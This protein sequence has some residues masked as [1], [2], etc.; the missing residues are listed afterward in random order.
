MRFPLGMT[1]TLGLFTLMP[2]TSARAQFSYGRDSFIYGGYQPSMSY[3]NAPGYSQVY[4]D[5]SNGI[6][7]DGTALGPRVMTPYSQPPAGSTFGQGTGLPTVYARPA[8]GPQA[9][10]VRPTATT[11]PN[12]RMRRPPV[13]RFFRR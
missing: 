2:A 4:T 11:N 8:Q 12:I 1:I 13:R 10:V 9:S 7:A 3:Y 5:P 6:Y